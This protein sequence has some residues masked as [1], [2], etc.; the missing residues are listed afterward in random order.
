MLAEHESCLFGQVPFASE[1]SSHILWAVAFEEYD[2]LCLAR[3][4]LDAD[5][6]DGPSSVRPLAV[7][8]VGVELEDGRDR[9]V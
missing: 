3:C 4:E 9:A 8:S 5:V 7:E 2:L 1:V 6:K